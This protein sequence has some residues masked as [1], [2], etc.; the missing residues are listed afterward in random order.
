M[1]DCGR[2]RV[3]GAIR[4]PGSQNMTSKRYVRVSQPGPS[5]IAKFLGI[6]VNVYGSS[7]PP[8]SVLLT[9]TRRRLTVEL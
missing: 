4:D 6:P 2:V 7:Q 1:S 3:K 8:V 9:Y 5:V